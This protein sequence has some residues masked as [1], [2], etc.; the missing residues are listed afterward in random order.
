MGKLVSGRV[1]K[2]PQ[3]DITSDRYEY[4]G[5]DQAEPNLGD[6]LIGPSSIGA[7]PLPPGQQYILVSTGIAGDRY[8][9]PNQ[10]GLIPG[11]ISIYNENS[12]GPAPEG[13]VGGLS[14]TT[15]L[16]LIGNAISAQGFLT[17]DGFPAPN[18]NIII[19]PPGNN[20]S[21]LFK[22]SNDFATSSNLV[23]NSSVGILT[24]GNGLNVGIGG[25]IFTV[26]STAIGINTSN[27]TQELDVNGDLRLRGTIYDFDNQPGT[28][29][30][31]LIKNSFGGVTWVNQSS[32]AA[33][34]GGTVTNIQYHNSAG[35]LGGASNFVFDDIN[36][37]IGIGSTQPRVTLDV[38]GISSFI[39]GVNIDNLNVSGV[40]TF[41]GITTV[42]GPTLFT[43]QLNVSGLSTFAGITTVT[44]TTLFTKQLNV[45]GVTTST[46]FIG[47][48]IG[49]VTGNVT[50]NINAPGVS[51]F[52]GTIFANGDLD[53]DGNTE[54]D[55]VNISE[56][57]Y[58]VGVSTLNGATRINGTLRVFGNTTLSNTSTTNLTSQQATVTGLSTFAGIT[59]VTGV[60]LFTRQLS[61]SG[62]ST[63]GGITTV[64]GP[65]LFTKQLNVSGVSTVSGSIFAAADEIYDIGTDVKKFNVIYARLFVGGIIGNAET[66]TSVSGG[67]ANVTALFVA[68]IS[69]FNGPI[70]TNSNDTYDIGTP[71]ER[72]NNVYANAFNGS[73]GTITNFNSTNGNI[74]N[75]TGTTGTI[76]TFD[77]TNLSS[78]NGNF[79][80]LLSAFSIVSDNLTSNRLN[81]TGISTFRNIIPSADN[82]YN[83]G[84]ISNRWSTVY[85]NS[86]VGAITGNADTA[87]K[88]TT[89]RNI[90]ITGDLS[91]NVNF[92]GSVNVTSIGTLANSG[93]IANTYGS[94]TTIPVFT[95]DSK[96]RIT[97]VTNTSINF[98]T[99]TV[100]QSDTIRTVSSS[101]TVLYPTFVDSNNNPANYESLFTDGDIF[102]NASTN[103]LTLGNITVSDTSV[104]NGNVTLGD[105]TTDTV[106]FNSRINSN[107]LPSTNASTGAD[108]NGKDL[109]GQSNLWRKVYAKEFVGAIA[110]NADTATKLTTARNIAITGDLSWNVNFD[111]SVNV[112][113][114]G[115]LANSGVIAN[116]YGSSTTIPVFAVDTKGRVTSV[117]NTSINFS[118]ATVAQSDTVKTVLT[119]T[120]TSFF[121]TFVNSNN[122]TA[123]FESLFTDADIFYNPSTNLLSL[124]S[125][126]VSDT[127]VFNGNVTLGDATTDTI[128][129]TGRVNSN[130]LPSTNAS[131]GADVNG[132]DLGGQSNLWRKV[133]AKE[134]VGAIAGN[135]DTATKLTTARNI[136]ITGDLSWNVN[137]DGSVNVT[138]TGTLANT[139]VTANTYGS[140]STVPVFTVDSKGRITSVTNTGITGINAASVSAAGANTQVQFNDNG[141]F[142]GNSNFTFNK[143]TNVLSV[144]TVVGNLT[145]NLTNTVTGTNTTELVRGNMADNDQ[146]RILVG[147]T[148]SDAGYAEI[149]T[150]DNG[151][152]PI[153]VRQYTGVFATLIRTAT[154]LDGSGNTSFPGTVTSN[155]LVVNTNGSTLYGPN[156]T[157]SRFLRIGGNGNADTTNASVVTTNG[158]L[159]LDAGSGAFATYLNFYKGTSG[160]AF[161]NGGAA[162]AVAWM[163]SDGDLWKGS[164]DNTG[165]P[166]WHSGNDGAGSGL[167]A[168]LLDGLNSSQFLRSDANS[169]ATGSYLF[170]R[171]NPAISNG[172]YA[173]PNNHIELRTGDGSNPI[174]GFHRSGFSATAL[175]H[176]GYGINS[177]RMRNADGNDGPIF[178]T[179]NDGA[180][181]GLDADLLDGLNSAT[182]DTAN[183][184]VARDASGD[185]FARLI[186]QTFANQTTISGGMVFRVNDST[187]NYLRICS[188]TQAIRTFLNVPTRTGGN[189]SGTWDINITGNSATTSG[190]TFSND[191][192]NKPIITTRTD[193]GFYEHDTAATVDG[194]PINSNTWMHM[195][196]CTHSNDTNYYSM[197]IAASFFNQT[198]LYYRSVNNNGAT[199]W[200]KIWHSNNDGAGSGL[201]ADLLDGI[202]SASF[203]RVDSTSV[204]T[205]PTY[206]Q[207]N[208]GTTSGSLSN[209]P[210]QAYST[211]TNSAFMSFHR[212]GSFAVNFGLD[213]DNVLRIGGWSAAANRFQLD[214]SGNG[215]YAGTVTANSDIRLKDNIEIIPNAL[216]KVSQIRGVT[217]TRNDQEDKE[218]RHAGVIAQEVEK[219]LPEV[220]M[221]GN[222]GI[223]SVAYGNLVSLLIE[224]I[225]EQQEQINNLTDEINKLK[226]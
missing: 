119:S 74:T 56:N 203:A 49:N 152:E 159:H 12:S 181:S 42:T 201:D 68:G 36:N 147:G 123:E 77:S 82:T 170:S 166:Y 212:A 136:A 40:S 142:A 118:T 145:G 149:A 215:T 73:S 69:T 44:G 97:S 17:N 162:N 1:K 125:L 86:F 4:L 94:S 130:V 195:I 102:Y 90:A 120:N 5:L 57:L 35:L 84:E 223:K 108:V 186:R 93:V 214:M 34:A 18:V 31:L 105:A 83:L 3:T 191:A 135:A 188:D 109:G 208:L 161:G 157:W 9:I 62:V 100:A 175:Y 225:K 143:T 85:A 163:G 8:W 54:L 80:T 179:F 174:I 134:F 114:V 185:I 72:F 124:T 219:V 178:S 39:G 50:G 113:S 126:S 196:A 59:T 222:D 24:I 153:H 217:F 32:L 58:V 151:T 209:P 172:S 70:R 158:N 79:D 13:L 133:Y 48:L 37:R 176:S 63:F 106:T 99:A 154:L 197:Q 21:V 61:V 43:K 95:V 202:N 87:T 26:S 205:V 129:F 160:V 96:G 171:N 16:I 6:P 121:P 20:G 164:A 38:L 200:S 71:F 187:D 65:T 207:S 165:S 89:A 7:K 23:F 60:T 111:G 55:N 19:S 192:V 138:N 41:A 173:T 64:T 28:V 92:D 76:T 194:W 81:V 33:G 51:T 117:T 184:I 88:L 27:P 211:G 103:L 213:S 139:G 204:F 110:G 45:S 140:S 221:E 115:T 91:W 127:S 190:S 29:L 78:N 193:S 150:A 146:F 226:K 177:L 25:T 198:D 107:V 22:E 122:S 210:L 182:T 10:G 155:N 2:T 167:D 169:T 183:T 116:T 156:S 131:T 67:T 218:K 220:V 144:P 30:Q 52:T 101:A 104:F 148:S 168:D 206:F 53:V 132:K 47:A 66:A 199:G 128:T 98:S 216:E 46:T 11:S 224:A 14:S 112:T 137:F 75:L 189:A 141:F 180:G 15:Q